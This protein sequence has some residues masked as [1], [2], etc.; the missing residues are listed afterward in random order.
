ML[1]PYVIALNQSQ[2]ENFIAF[3]NENRGMIEK[4]LV[5]YGAVKFQNVPLQTIDDFQQI[6]NSISDKFINYIDGNSP[7]TKLT[8]NVYTS[9]EYDKSQVITMHNE[10]SYSPLWPNQLYF[11]CLDVAETGGETLLADSREILA[12][13]DKGIVEEVRRK[14]VK[15]IRNLHGGM[16]MG[17]SWQDTFETQDKEQVEK[18]CSSNGVDYQWNDYD[19]LSIIYA[20]KG[21]IQHRN[22]NESVWFNQINQF[23]PSQLAA[24]LYDA[25]KL[26]YDDA[27]EFPTY[28]KFG[29]DTL[30]SEEIVKEINKT[31]ETV[32]IYPDWNINEFLV[33]DNEIVAHGRNSYTGDR[34]VLVSMA[35]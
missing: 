4:E 13:M 27:S 15:Y 3:Y 11:T 19:S 9:T 29:D 6:T 8:S 25:L 17:P 24:D 5:K 10:L 1:L 34:K 21:I 18:Y 23:H 32:T 20:T 16:G 22:S 33:V 31:I 12:A 30:I 35:K 28:V 7:R 26:M 14:G 2:S